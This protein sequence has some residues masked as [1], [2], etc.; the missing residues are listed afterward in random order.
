VV[1]GSAAGS[2]EGNF[3]SITDVA[4]VAGVSIAT[5]SR[6]RHQRKRRR[7]IEMPRRPTLRTGNIAVVTLGHSNGWL[8]LPVM[9]S[10]LAGIQRG[11]RQHDLHLM[12]YEVPD[13]TLSANMP[14]QNNTDGVIVFISASA[15]PAES[16]ALL[17]SI[18]QTAPAIWAMGQAQ[19]VPGVDHVAPDNLGAG[20][21]AFNSLRNRGAS[22]FAFVCNEPHWPF[23]RQRGHGFIQAAADEGKMA[24]AFLVTEDRLMAGGFGQ[25]FTIASSLE[26]LIEKLARASPRPDGLFIANDLTTA[27]AYPMLLHHGIAP[28]R[29][30]Q[31]VSC[32]NEEIRLAMLS[33]RPVS[34]DL[35]AEEIGYRSV[36]RLLGRMQSPD[37]PALIIQVAAQIPP[38]QKANPA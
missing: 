13:L 3:V 16:E 5:V 32:D 11:A 33:P 27:R 20:Y 7:K 24:S 34:I 29:D 36:V 21:L 9:A 35:R 30:V 37:D 17:T 4:R 15:S 19:A 14:W 25:S 8:Q 2:E 22:E 23:M 6:D 26:S 10:A 38:E 31:I 18:G 1:D 28:G 12:L